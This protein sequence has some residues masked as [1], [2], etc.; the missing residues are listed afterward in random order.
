MDPNI[1]TVYQA[2]PGLGAYILY[3]AIA[4][5]VAYGVMLLTRDKPPKSPLDGSSVDPSVRGSVLQYLIGRRRISSIV[6]WVGNTWVQEIEQDTGGKGGGGGKTKTN[7]YWQSGQHMLCLGVGNQLSAIYERGEKI[8]DNVITPTTHPTGSSLNCTDGSVFRIYWGESDQAKDTNLSNYTGIDSGFRDVFY[9]MWDRKALG[10]QKVWPVLEYVVQVP[11]QNATLFGNATWIESDVSSDSYSASVSDGY[12][13]YLDT[14]D[15][16]WGSTIST[17]PVYKSRVVVLTTDVDVADLVAGDFISFTYD[18]VSFESKVLKVVEDITAAGTYGVVTLDDIPSHFYNHS[19]TLNKKGFTRQGVNIAAMLH[20]L[21]FSPF[22]FGL[23]Y[24]TDMYN[25]TDLEAVFDLFDAGADLELPGSLNLKDNKS[26]SDGI[27]MILQDAGVALHWDVATGQFR[28]S[29]A[30]AGDT[31][32]NFTAG[33]YKASNNYDTYSKGYSVLEPQHRHYVFKDNNRNYEDS[34]IMLADDQ[35]AQYALMPNTKSIGLY[36]ITD[37]LTASTFAARRDREFYVRG[38]FTLEMTST[39]VAQPLFGLYT[40][41]GIAGTFRMAKKQVRPNMA[42]FR[43]S[44]LEDHYSASSVAITMTHRGV[45]LDQYDEVFE[46]MQFRILEVNKFTAPNTHGIYLLRIRN[47]Q[48]S[49][50]TVVYLSQDNSTYVPVTSTTKY[51]TG[52]VLTSDLAID[53]ATTLDTGPTFT[54]SGTDLEI[55]RNLTSNEYE[56]KAGTQVAIINSE[57]FYLQNVTATAND[58]EY[59]LIGL[60]RARQGTNFE[61]HSIGDE[62]YIGAAADLGIISDPMILTGAN[63]YAKS[64]P[65]NSRTTVDIAD[66]TA[67]SLTYAG[68]GYKPLPCV[69]LFD[70]TNTH[71]WDTGESLVLDWDYR[72]TIGGAGAGLTIADEP[73]AAPGPDGYFVLEITAAGGSTVVRSETVDVSEFTYTQAMMTTDWGSE[74]SSFDVHV[75]AVSSGLRSEALVET[76]TKES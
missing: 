54:L 30:S 35:S 33:Q 39:L 68:G 48:N 34:G 32:T 45:I 31:P 67:D 44:F 13:R 36:T 11:S 2:G 47:S 64:V 20:Q 4:A 40:F 24:D 9:I 72:N 76:F 6:G 10:G 37:L 55:V 21:L 16:V 7:V 58:G 8:F 29:A 75:Y 61:A 26:I 12:I 51:A 41:E 3:T 28:F 49:S 15:V 27:S 60:M 5:A 59:T 14:E 17:S 62:V 25:L 46:D 42:K 70:A 52:G 63:L 38:G 18:S 74:P 66:V 73:Y 65:F 43:A 71:I 19:I 69:N 23:G 50:S 53:T 57:I 1:I 56:W 22:P